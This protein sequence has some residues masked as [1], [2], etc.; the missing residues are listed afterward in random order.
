M[1]DVDTQLKYLCALY[2]TGKRKA[3]KKILLSKTGEDMYVALAATAHGLK[4]KEV[5]QA[6]WQPLRTYLHGLSLLKDV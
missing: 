6:I 3:F 4:I 2:G 5:T 1:L